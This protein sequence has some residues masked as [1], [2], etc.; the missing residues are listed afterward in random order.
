MTDINTFA[1]P[2]VTYVVEVRPP[3]MGERFLNGAKIQTAER[4]YAATAY[5]VIVWVED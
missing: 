1:D 2:N 3:R 5:P 4:D